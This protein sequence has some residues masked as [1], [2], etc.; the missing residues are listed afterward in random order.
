MRFLACSCWK[1]CWLICAY[2]HLTVLL[3]R[4]TFYEDIVR[5]RSDFIFIMCAILTLTLFLCCFVHMCGLVLLFH[6]CYLSFISQKECEVNFFY[7]QYLQLIWHLLG[8]WGIF[9]YLFE[10]VAC[11]INLFWFHQNFYGIPMGVIPL[12]YTNTFARIFYG[13]DKETVRYG[14]VMRNLFCS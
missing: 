12:G 1:L 7:G 13:P 9:F 5:R 3:N 6:Y 2:R 4:S 8:A 11:L 14:K 10:F